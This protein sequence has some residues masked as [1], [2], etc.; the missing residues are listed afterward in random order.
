MDIEM[1][2]KIRDIEACMADF[3]PYS[4]K[5]DMTMVISINLD[6]ILDHMEM[7]HYMMDL[8]VSLELGV[9]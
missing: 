5:H 2:S 6:D 9:Y 4:G 7:N 1:E 3:N 8:D